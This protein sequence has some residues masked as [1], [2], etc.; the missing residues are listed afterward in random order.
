MKRLGLI[1]LALTALLL[2]LPAT[3][4]AQGDMEWGVKGGLNISGLRG[5]GT[6][7]RGPLFD[8]KRGIVAGVFGVFDL[9]PEF[10]IEVDALFSM[11][12]GKLSG[13]GVDPNGNPIIN[14]EGFFILDY[15]EFPILARYN[16]PVQGDVTPHLYAGPTIALKVSGR[17]RYS[18]LPG[19]DLDAARTL[20]SGLAFGA[21]VDLALGARSVV[22]DGRFGL[23]LTNAF[24]WSGPD[25]KNDTF[26]IM[27]GVSF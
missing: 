17:A 16:L 3:G 22:L 11:K 21:S 4:R 9:A 2:A 1:G 19:A 12:G 15:L 7:L 26:S 27:A 23:G 24:R 14:T 5:S 10:G 8:T 6:G 20:D 18:Q 13:P 25:L